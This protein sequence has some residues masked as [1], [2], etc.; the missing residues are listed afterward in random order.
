MMHKIIKFVLVTIKLIWK[1]EN[2]MKGS[3][4]K[5]NTPLQFNRKLAMFCPSTWKIQ[6]K[7]SKLLFITTRWLTLYIYAWADT[8]LWPHKVVGRKILTRVQVEEKW[9]LR[10]K[11]NVLNKGTPELLPHQFSSEL[12]LQRQDNRPET[13]S[14]PDGNP[15]NNHSA[16]M[17]SLITFKC[18]HN[19]GAGGSEREKRK[20]HLKYSN[21]NKSRYLLLTEFGIRM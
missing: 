6:L 10:S 16:T 19:V 21:N 13:F 11:C 15:S 4:H 18:I 3:F 12:S 17:P 1:A 9:S 7:I 2:I 14:K 5:I 8:P 20:H